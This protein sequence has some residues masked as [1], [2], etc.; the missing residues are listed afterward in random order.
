MEAQRQTSDLQQEL[1]LLRAKNAKLGRELEILR[2][3]REINLGAI[4]ALKAEIATLEAERLRQEE[5]MAVLRGVLGKGSINGGLKVHDFE[6][7]PSG[8][9]GGYNFKFTVS[10]TQKDF[11]V[12]SGMIE[13]SVS[14]MLNGER[15]ELRLAEISDEE[16]SSVKMR[17]RHFQNVSGEIL[18]PAEFE[19]TSFIVNVTGRRCC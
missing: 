9:S 15:K 17:F 16:E 6:L 4:K 11:G 8:A 7:A 13:I 10:Q 5:E 18:L 12:A 3:S 2:G 19:P 14:G 1:A